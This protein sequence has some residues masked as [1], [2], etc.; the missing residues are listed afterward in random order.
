VSCLVVDLD[1]GGI[2]RETL[3]DALGDVHAIYH[4]T[5]SSTPAH[6]KG[7]AIMPLARPCPVSLWPRMW[8][9]V[10]TRLGAEIDRACK[11]PARVFYLP[12][13]PSGGHRE[14][15]VLPGALLEVDYI[16]LPM[17]AEERKVE[18]RRS[19]RREPVMSGK[20]DLWHLLKTDPRVREAAA[21]D[22]GARIVEQRATC[23]PCPTCGRPDVWFIIDKRGGKARC[24]HVNSCGAEF[25]LDQL[26]EA[27]K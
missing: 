8:Q 16:G 12:S 23:I 18:Q 17:T 13:H 4:S 21:I 2:K 3:R 6:P 20:R 14:F 24:N 27:K 1:E 5:Y 26:L 9:W 22:L 25:W 7:R 15:W 11:D 19:R 10:E